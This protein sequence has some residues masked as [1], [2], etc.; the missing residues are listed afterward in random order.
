MHFC[1]DRVL[2]MLG[3]V[4]IHL[5]ASALTALDQSAGTSDILNLQLPAA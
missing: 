1:F 5:P 3:E 4:G 2:P